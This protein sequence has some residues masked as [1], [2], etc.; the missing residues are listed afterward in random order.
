VSHKKLVVIV[1]LDVECST[2]V[3]QRMLRNPDHGEKDG[4]HSDYVGQHL[5]G[6][7]GPLPV[8]PWGIGVC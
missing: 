8:N 6:L 3:E 4:E 1:Y 7:V 2:R 5:G